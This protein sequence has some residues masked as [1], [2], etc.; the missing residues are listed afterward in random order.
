LR[1]ESRPWSMPSDGLFAVDCEPQCKK[2]ELAIMALAKRGNGF[3]HNLAALA[4][5]AAGLA[6]SPIDMGNG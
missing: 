1:E 3:N 6:P 4:T 5:G 2:Q